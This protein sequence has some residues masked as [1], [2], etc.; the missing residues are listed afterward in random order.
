MFF[1]ILYRVDTVE[2]ERR[3]QAVALDRLA[4][5]RHRFSRFAAQ[6][7]TTQARLGALSIFY[8]N[9]RGALE[10]FLSHAK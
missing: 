8:L 2:G 7:M 3:E 10:G 5:A 6:Q 4:H 1:V 9:D